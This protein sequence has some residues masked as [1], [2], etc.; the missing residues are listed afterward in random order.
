MPPRP[1]VV[2]SIVSREKPWKPATSTIL[3]WSS[4]VRT[5]SPRISRI[6]ALRVRRVGEDAGLRAGQRDGLLA[7]VVDRHRDERAGDAL[8]RREQHVELAHVRRR[9]HLVGEV[10]QPVGRLAHRRDGPDD[11]AG[12]AACA[13]T[14]R[15]ATCLIL[16]GSATDEPP[17][18][19]TTV[20]NAGAVTADS[21]LLDEA[22]APVRPERRAGPGSR[23]GASGRAPARAPARRAGD[24]RP[25]RRAR[26]PGCRRPPARRRGSS[27]TPRRAA[28]ASTDVAFSSFARRRPRLGPAAGEKLLGERLER[29][30]A[31]RPARSPASP[32][33]HDDRAVV[34]RVLEDRA[35]EH[36]PVEERDGQAGRD[37]AR[38]ARASVRL[39]AE[40]WT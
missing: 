2:I 28:A 7:E 4:A 21:V 12:R 25:R 19:I 10:D 1:S 20:S 30:R 31:S 38:R 40:P 6:L 9:R 27:P 15:R 13:S 16:S 26:H 23:A 34:H 37:P 14:S 29:R 39:A 32:S 22:G 36:D 11:V 24:A 8:A 3:P 17:N 33:E 18:F 5:R 35:C